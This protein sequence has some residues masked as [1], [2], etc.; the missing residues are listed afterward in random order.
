MNKLYRK[1]EITF[2]IMWIVAYVLISSVADGISQDLGI[3]KCVTAACQVPMAALLLGWIRR[4]DLMGKYGLVSPTVS[5]SRFLY[6]FPLAIIATA[7]LWGGF[8]LR[9]GVAGCFFWVVSMCCVGFLE[10]VIFRGLLFRAMEKNGLTSAVVVS[11]LTF[12]MGHIVNLFNASGQDLTQTLSQIIF[13][14]MVG[15]VLVLV[16]LRGGS[17]V[18]CIVFHACNNALSAFGVELALSPLANLAVNLLLSV[19]LLGGYAWY[20]WK[21]F[22]QPASER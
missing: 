4:N 10:E 7:G 5:A 12:G 19:V 6:Y 3:E 1:S 14:V 18:P 2:A 8:G 11:S 20:L 22:P 9:Y 13:A 15:F 17:L 16:L 21:L